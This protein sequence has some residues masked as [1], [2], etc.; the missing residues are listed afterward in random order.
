MFGAGPFLAPTP[1]PVPRVRKERQSESEGDRAAAGKIGQIES[2]TP[3]VAPCSSRA[4][5]QRVCVCVWLCVYVC[6]CSFFQTHARGTHERESQQR[7]PNPAAVSSH[8]SSS[9][10][11]STI[12]TTN[13]QNKKKKKQRHHGAVM[14]SNFNLQSIR[15]GASASGWDGLGARRPPPTPVPSRGLVAGLPVR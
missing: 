9:S 4:V 3:R 15:S 2:S 12:I 13:Q 5:S 14:E 7:L 1:T 8:R 10:S 11:S 6:A